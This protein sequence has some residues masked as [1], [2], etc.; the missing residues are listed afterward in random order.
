[1][2]AAMLR[3]VRKHFVNDMAPRAVQRHNMRAW[4][5]SVRYLGDRWLLANPINKPLG[6]QA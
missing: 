4:V 6:E 1:M 2:K 5:R 3:R